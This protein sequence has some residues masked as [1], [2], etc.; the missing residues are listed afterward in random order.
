MMKQQKL[1]VPLRCEHCGIMTNNSRE[2]SKHMKTAHQEEVKRY[3][4]DQ[5]DHQTYSKSEMEGHKISKNHVKSQV[6]ECPIFNEKLSYG[7]NLVRHIENEHD[8]KNATAESISEDEEIKI[9]YDDEEEVPFTLPPQFKTRFYPNEK[10]PTQVIFKSLQ[11][12]MLFAKATNNL[13]KIIKNKAKIEIKDTKVEFVNVNKEDNETDAIVKVSDA[14]GE[15]N[16]RIKIWGTKEN[17]KRHNSTVQINKMEGEEAEHVGRLANNILQPLLEHFL[18]NV[19][20]KGLLQKPRT[21]KPT[22][23][24]HNA[25]D[26]TIV[27]D[28]ATEHCDLFGVGLQSLRS[29]RRHRRQAHIETEATAGTKRRA[30]KAET[31][32]LNPR[33]YDP[34]FSPPAKLRVVEK[35]KN[36]IAP[37]TKETV[38][39]TTSEEAPPIIQIKCRECDF[40]CSRREQ[41]LEHKRNAK[42]ESRAKES[43]KQKQIQRSRTFLK[44]KMPQRS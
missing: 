20:A 22:A 41:L 15:G 26:Q 32:V 19:N 9:S 16:A 31:N 39:E 25:A 42:A 27:L 4:C 3:E 43:I 13:N 24:E 40:T 7:L 18:V 8:N 34:T 5:C 1:I 12:S 17:S 11:K 44:V 10:E 6:V 21:E 23:H 36:K 28:L 35:D 29:L 38:T 33:K 30:T 14:E 37:S 2:F